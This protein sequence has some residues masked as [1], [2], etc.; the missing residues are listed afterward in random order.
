M[1]VKLFAPDPA[2]DRLLGSHMVDAS[3]VG[4][5][6]VDACIKPIKVTLGDGRKVGIKRRG[7]KL[8]LSIGDR[9]GEGLLRRL[10]NGPSEKRMFHEALAEAA[11]Q[12]GAEISEE[13]GVYF[14]AVPESVDAQS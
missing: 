10:A 6:Y 14:L 13:D 5:N 8:T 2:H 7:L 4:I 9:S 3:G 11:G 1:K 12:L